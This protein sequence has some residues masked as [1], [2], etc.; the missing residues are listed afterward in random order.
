[1]KQKLIENQKFIIILYWLILGNIMLVNIW[2]LPVT[3]IF[4]FWSLLLVVSISPSLYYGKFFLKK[5]KI[6]FALL[7]YCLFTLCVALG[8]SLLYQLFAQLELNGYFP[9]SAYFEDTRKN[10]FIEDSVEV[11]LSSFLVTLG[12]TGVLLLIEH[13]KI[14]K[15]LLETQLHSL[16]SQVN[17]HFMFNILNHINF[18]IHKDKDKASVLLIQYSKILRYQLYHSGATYNKLGDEIQFLKNYIEVE[19]F[20][21]NG[22]LSIKI[23]L[24]MTDEK[25]KVPTLLF[26]ILV[27][28]AFKHVYRRNGYVR[29]DLQQEK[30]RIDFKVSNSM[31]D[32]ILKKKDG[33]LGLANLKK[34]LNL[35]NP[36]KHELI[37]IE[38]EK[39]FTSQLIINI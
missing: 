19:R 38:K 29:I 1:M 11:L 23:D 28:N 37:L 2:E 26:F 39:E 30:N 34:Q 18:L 9:L 13:S 36:S 7:I 35:L 6:K 25:V 24:N 4:G 3:E 16:Q 8:I 5:Q 12:I 21:F 22:I 20:R 27:E 33:G 31:S 10:S 14:H 15:V 32:K 17:P